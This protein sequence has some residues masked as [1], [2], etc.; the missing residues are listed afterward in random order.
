MFLSIFVIVEVRVRIMQKSHPTI[1]RRHTVVEKWFG[2]NR[3]ITTWNM[4]IDGV[5]A[6][7]TAKGPN[8]IAVI[9][10]LREAVTFHTPANN[11]YQFIED[12]KKFRLEEKELTPN[13]GNI[14]SCAQRT[15]KVSGT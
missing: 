12:G 15:S 4:L 11:Q 6:R 13:P 7:S 8:K 14:S 1:W 5:A 3:T 9:K 10:N 2:K